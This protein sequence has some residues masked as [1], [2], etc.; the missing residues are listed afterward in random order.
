LCCCETNGG[1]TVHLVGTIVSGKISLPFFFEAV[2][3]LYVRHQTGKY[4]FRALLIFL[5][6]ASETVH[7]FHVSQSQIDDLFSQTKWCATGTAVQWC[8]I[9]KRRLRLNALG[10]LVAGITH[11]AT[12]TRDGLRPTRRLLSRYSDD[13]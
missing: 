12:L 3:I 7:R 10:I 4:F 2:P 5:T 13:A 1:E 11:V 8:I 9:D 6:Q